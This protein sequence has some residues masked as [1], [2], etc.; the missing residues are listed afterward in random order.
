M[1]SMSEKRVLGWRLKF[2]GTHLRL[3]YLY[4]TR[5]EAEIAL[6]R[7]DEWHAAGMVPDAAKI[8][9][10]VAKPK[11]PPVDKLERAIAELRIGFEYNQL[12]LAQERAANSPAAIIRFWEGCET[13]S[14]IALKTAQRF[15]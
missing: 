12:R 3:A 8:V 7:W 14:A 11:A 13:E 6:E 15:L 10:I 4:S 1:G 9:R 5:R 2:G